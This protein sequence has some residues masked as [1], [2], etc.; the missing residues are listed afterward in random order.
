[1]TI[2]RRRFAKTAAAAG[3]LLLSP[4]VL[5][6]AAAQANNRVMRA[7][8]HGDL[9]VFD[10][11]W[12]TANMTSYHAS[13]VYDTL[14]AMDANFQPKPQMVGKFD[15][16]ED[17]KTY[18]FQL[19]DGLKFH[20]GTPVTAADC[21]ASLR[22]W[23]ARDG[24][25]QHM[26]KRVKDTPTKDDKTFQIVLSEP[27]GLVLD[28]M[29]KLTTNCLYVMRKKDAETDPNQQVTTKIGSGPFIFN[30]KE[31]RAGQRYVYDKNPDYV[32]RNEPASGAAGGKVVN[33][34][35]VI[36]DNMAD[37]RT[38][39]AALQA[40]EIDFYEFVPIDLIDAVES[41]SNIAVTLLNKGG[42]LGLMR[43][44]FLHPPFNNADMRRGMLHLVK[45][46]D[47]VKAVFGNPK[48][49]R[50][51]GS[52]FGCGNPMENDANTDW[53]KKQDIE[54]AKDYF[55][56]AGYD[57]RPITVLQAT[58]I[59]FMNDAALIIAQWLRQAGCNVQL[60]A[61]DWGG[62]VTRRAVKETPDKGGWNIF[63]TWASTYAYD[64]PVALSAHAASGQNAWFG[65]P[66]DDKHEKMRDEWAAAPTLEARRAV[67]RRIQENY[68][69]F[70]PMVYLGQWTQPC[71]HRKNVQGI[72]GMPE[73]V[74]F[75]NIKKV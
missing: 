69:D 19:R 68:W 4:N 61:S 10:P 54:K 71:A 6:K 13:M 72:I 70:V 39:I 57:G 43:L 51:C 25:A 60:A 28:A 48:Y 34:D 1:M 32:P 31:V 16:S 20:D 59:K 8:M 73:L 7:V 74:P 42:N 11:V 65:W 37:E 12:T 50:A 56:K 64:S 46:E 62:V 15:L 29:A 53:L 33:L 49:Y 58:S 63:I 55:K 45:Q 3:S 52:T 21:V 5:R 17:K 40:G 26:F 75:W 38:A 66:S 14:F 35:R 44:N 30:E 9:R 23:A 27:Y 67:A 24:G 36:W 22:R 41:D 47:I 2:S 18:T